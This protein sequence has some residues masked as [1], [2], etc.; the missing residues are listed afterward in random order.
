MIPPEHSNLHFNNELFEDE[1][2]N[3]IT[4][5]YF[6]NGAGVAVGDVNNDG[7]QDIGFSG[8][9]VD[10]KLYLNRGNLQ[11]E[12]VTTKAQINTNGKWAT[13]ATMVDI[14]NDG[15]L[16]L[17][18]CAAGPYGPQRRENSLF[19]NQ[20]DGTFM[21]QA[22]AFG[23]ADSGHTTQAAFFDYDL[24]GRLGCYIS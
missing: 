6:Y 2:L 18:V 17:Y 15:W 14:N 8:N 11:F 19:I 22:H 12:D 3:I 4:F 1:N 16:D 5:E 9:M 7:L 10:G 23:L 13:G 20:K 21:D 24:D